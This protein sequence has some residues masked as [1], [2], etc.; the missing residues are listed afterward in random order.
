MSRLRTFAAF[1]AL[2]AFICLGFASASADGNMVSNRLAADVY[3]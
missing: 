2:A 1:T 3:Y